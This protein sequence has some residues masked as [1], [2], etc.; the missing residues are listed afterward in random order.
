MEEPKSKLEALRWSLTQDAVEVRAGA[1]VD[2]FST[3]ALING[4]DSEM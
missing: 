2:I 1:F 4:L 3:D